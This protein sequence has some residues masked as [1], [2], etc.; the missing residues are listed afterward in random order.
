[1]ILCLASKTGEWKD[2]EGGRTLMDFVEAGA[3][4]QFQTLRGRTGYKS[5]VNSNSLKS[6]S[7]IMLLM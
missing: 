3:P 7:I 2:F 1:M 5:R 6:D 4:V